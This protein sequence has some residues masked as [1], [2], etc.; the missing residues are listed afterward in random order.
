MADEPTKDD[1]LKRA[2]ELDVEG[3]SS[4]T[5]DELAAAIAGAEPEDGVIGSE[6]TP[7]EQ[8]AAAAL[9][10]ARESADEPSSADV[11]GRPSLVELAQDRAARREATMRV[12]GSPTQ[13]D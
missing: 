11:V 6:P 1:L 7:E 10:A 9:D 5:N 4:M 2:A 12:I 3:R 8:E 13:E